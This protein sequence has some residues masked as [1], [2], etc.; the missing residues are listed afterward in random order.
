[1]RVFITGSESFIG[2][3]LW[4]MLLSRGHELSGMD[5]AAPRRRDAVQLDL[6]DPNLAER[7]PEN[8]TIIH[9]AAVST[10]QLCKANPTEAL[11]INITGT[12]RLAQAA[13]KR[14]CTQFIFAS[15]EWVYGDVANNEIQTEDTPIDATRIPGVYAFS[16]LAGERVLSFS[17]LPNVT[18]LRFGIVYGPRERNW[19]AVESLVDKVRKGENVQVGSL[20]TGRKFIHLTDLCEGIIA[21]MGQKGHQ[22]F[23]LPGERMITLGDVLSVGQKVLGKRIETTETAP[24]KPSIRNPDGARAAKVLGWRPRIDF[25]AGMKNLS[26]YLTE[27][28]ARA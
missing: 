19:S 10:D 12:L 27:R 5:V 6:R 11:D 9:L 15:T 3:A 26:Q 24:D 22:A 7:I 21:S 18:T 20:K 23:N 25:E 14:Y 28:A 8:A 1:M 16:K 2:S 17:G 13:L 4:D